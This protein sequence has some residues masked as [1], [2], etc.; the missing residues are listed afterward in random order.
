MKLF[1]TVKTLH[2]NNKYKIFNIGTRYNSDNRNN[3][4]SI[5]VINS[6]KCR[7]NIREEVKLVY[8][9]TSSKSQNA[10]ELATEKIETV[11]K[12]GELFTVSK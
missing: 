10:A 12:E 11:S 4:N 8:T 3:R 2:N 5:Y 6:V 1:N 9:V 7:Y